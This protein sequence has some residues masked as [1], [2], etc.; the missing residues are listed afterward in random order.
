[1]FVWQSAIECNTLYIDADNHSG[2]Y[3]PWP[4]DAPD[5]SLQELNLNTDKAWQLLQT[6][7]TGITG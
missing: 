7:L 6:A 4:D 5:G 3:C 2:T 1:M